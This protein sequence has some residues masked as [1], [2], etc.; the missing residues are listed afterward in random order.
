MQMRL[1]QWIV[2][3]LAVVLVACGDTSDPPPTAGN[4]P[5]SAVASTTPAPTADGITLTTS[6]KERLS[7]VYF[8]AK[9]AITIKFDLAKVGDDIFADVTGNGGRP[10]VHIETNGEDYNFS[11]MGGGL[12]LHTTKSFIAKARTQAETQPKE[13]STDGFAFIGDMHLLDAML[14]LPEVAHLPLLSRALGVRGFTGSDY[15]AS[16]VLHKMGRQSA[17]ALGITLQKLDTAASAN[18]YCEAYPNSWDSCYGMCGPGC[19]CWSWV[20]GDCCYH[21]GC[22]VHDSWCRQGQWWYCY[23]ITAVIALFGC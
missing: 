10:I 9:D 3:A 7:G 12:T 17:D 15:P 18:G 13:V 23:N 22:A 8:D 2:P 11:Y 19:S 6:T 16:L 14:A 20:C 21:Y 1:S 4:A 5:P